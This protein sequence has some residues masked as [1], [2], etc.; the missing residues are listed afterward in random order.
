MGGGT[1]TT[2]QN[3]DHLFPI[4]YSLSFHI[5]AHSFALFCTHAKLNSFIF[6]RFRTLCEKQPGVGYPFASQRSASEL[7][8]PPVVKWGKLLRPAQTDTLESSQ[9]PL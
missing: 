4:P 2:P 8:L 1:G 5:L 6:K 3:L 9:F 7:A